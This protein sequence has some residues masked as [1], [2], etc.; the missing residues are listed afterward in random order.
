MN[1]N[2]TADDPVWTQPIDRMPM[3]QAFPLLGDSKEFAEKQVILTEDH[4]RLFGVLSNKATVLHHKDAVEM[5]DQAMTEAYGQQPKIDIHSYK[6]GAQIKARFTLPEEPTV[7][8]GGNDVSTFHVLMYN[9]YDR[10]L[11]FK[12]R[13][14]AYRLICDNG[15]VIGEDIASVKGADL[16]DGWSPEGVAT[17]IKHMMKNSMQIYDLWKHWQNLELSYLDGLEAVGTKLP[18]KAIGAIEARES[19]FP[20]TIWDYY[21]LITAWSTHESKT[22]R[23]KTSFEGTISNIFYGKKNPLYRLYSEVGLMT[24][25]EATLVQE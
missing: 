4:S 8:L 24:E 5:I 18:K 20:M 9:S 6:Q 19:E 14:G 16:L 15:M 3:I 22:E 23:A 11:P 13:V 25:E 17:K 2:V 10:S 1:L 21:N 12:L 7:D